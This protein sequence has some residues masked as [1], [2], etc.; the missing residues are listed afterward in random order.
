MQKDRPAKMNM[1]LVYKCFASW[2]G[3]SA[4]QNLPVDTVQSVNK[5][6]M[7]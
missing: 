4:Q 6:I 1:Y 2:S 7:Q 3:I 5:K